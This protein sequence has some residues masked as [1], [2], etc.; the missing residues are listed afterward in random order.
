V[1]YMRS[2]GYALSAR[3]REAAT[4]SLVL[5]GRNDKILD[6][7]QAPRFEAELP[8]GKLVWVEECGHCAHL[9]APDF[10]ADVIVRWLKGEDV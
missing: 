5:W 9:E 10:A 2:G 3:V 8:A 4:P 1:A 6:P 7:A